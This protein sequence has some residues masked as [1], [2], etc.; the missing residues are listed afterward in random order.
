CSQLSNVVTCSIGSVAK[1]STA[2]VDI[3]VEPKA[4]TQD[5][6]I[7]AHAIVSASETDPIPGN[8]SD[9]EPTT[10]T[11]GGHARPK[12]ATP[13]IASFVIAYK[14]CTSGEAG[15]QHGSPLSHPSCGNPQASSGFLTSGTP[16]ANARGANFI[17]QI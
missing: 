9:S 2:S 15:F 4:V 14:Q 6:Q 3:V 13:L 12:G 5:T 16:D 11:R 10:V 8:N 17:G 7:A 1:G